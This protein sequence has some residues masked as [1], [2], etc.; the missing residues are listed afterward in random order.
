[1][2]TV[3]DRRRKDIGD[4]S[5]MKRSI[6]EVGLIEPIVID[7]NATLVCG[8]RRLL[9]CQELGWTE[10]DTVIKD[11][12]NASQC[13]ID[14]NVVRKDFTPSEAVAIWEALDKKKTRVKEVEEVEDNY[15]PI[16]TVIEPPRRERAAAITGMSKNTLHKAKVVI[17]SGNDDL[18]EAMDETGNVDNAYKFVEKGANP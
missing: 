3:G 10:I 15:C 12:E 13:E 16:G 17:E 4:L 6:S 11:K 8:Y 1:M 7:E 2:I 14:E 18:I 9:S 5:D